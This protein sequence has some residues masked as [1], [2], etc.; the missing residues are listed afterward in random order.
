MKHS[1]NSVA[2]RRSLVVLALFLANVSTFAQDGAGKIEVGNLEASSVAWM[3]VLNQAGGYESHANTLISSIWNE[4]GSIDI[5][6]A[7]LSAVNR[8]A[9]SNTA[10]GAKSSA[11]L[12]ISSIY[13]SR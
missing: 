12:S 13:S 9:V 11:N 5:G 7:E 1:V 8:M 10:I 6:R 2:M 4:G 3:A